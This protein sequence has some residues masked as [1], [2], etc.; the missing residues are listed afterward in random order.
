MVKT[1]FGYAR[2]LAAFL[3]FLWSAR[4]R[5]GW[6]DAVEEDH[7]AYLVWRRRDA[8]GPRV[9]G[10]TWNREVAGVDAF[11]RGAVRRACDNKSDPAG[12]PTEWRG[13]RTGAVDSG[14]ATSGD[15]CPGRCGKPGGVAASSELSAV[16]GCRGEGIRRGG[17]AAGGLP[18]QVGSP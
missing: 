2:D 6:R 7:L 15:V 10:A 11:Y 1:R 18:R 3:A 13:T 4:G 16:A 14:R 8:D 12:G 5:K 17:P 9:A